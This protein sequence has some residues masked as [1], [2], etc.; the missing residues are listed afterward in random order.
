[1]YRNGPREGYPGDNGPVASCFLPVRRRSQAT[2]LESFFWS[3]PST[4]T[5]TAGRPC[6]CPSLVLPTQPLWFRHRPSTVLFR[7][8]RCMET[9]LGVDHVPTFLVF[10]S[11]VCRDSGKQPTKGGRG[12]HASAY[13]SA[14]SV[15]LGF[16]FSS[17]NRRPPRYE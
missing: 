1:V 9:S 4:L 5:T 16:F 17:L 7:R 8:F 11:G 2:I 3:L 12:P 10:F 15:L 14:C 6:L 13:P